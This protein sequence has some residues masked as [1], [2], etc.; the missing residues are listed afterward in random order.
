MVELLD[1]GDLIGLAVLGFLL[2]IAAA[3]VRLAAAGSEGQS[4]HAGKREGEK[5]VHHVVFHFGFL[6]IYLILSGR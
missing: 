2:G 4:H 6:Q 1:D 3:I 5:L